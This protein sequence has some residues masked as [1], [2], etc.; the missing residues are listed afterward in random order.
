MNNYERRLFNVNDHASFL[1]RGN[2]D[3]AGFEE[4][5][6]RH[7][8]PKQRA[9]NRSHDRRIIAY[10][11]LMTTSSAGTRLVTGGVAFQGNVLSHPPSPVDSRR[12][13]STL[14]FNKRPCSQA[15]QTQGCIILLLL[16]SMMERKAKSMRAMRR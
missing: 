16:L 12:R 4:A 11:A 8:R 7:L 6:R 2:D 5:F 10:L 13:Q 15:T 9:H 1:I 3:T 14:E